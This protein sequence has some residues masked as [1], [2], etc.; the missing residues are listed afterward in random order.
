M[1]NKDFEP[2]MKLN[3]NKYNIIESGIFFFFFFF[4]FFFCNLCLT[5]L[6]TQKHILELF[7]NF[8]F[9]EVFTVFFNSDKVNTD[10]KFLLCTC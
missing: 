8:F 6:H 10:C 7:L 2:W 3:N 5:N 4:F 9:L 1:L